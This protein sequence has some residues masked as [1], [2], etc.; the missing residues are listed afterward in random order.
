MPVTVDPN[1]TPEKYYEEVKEMWRKYPKD[2]NFHQQAEILAAT[3]TASGLV[4]DREKT[5]AA[6]MHTASIR[7]GVQL[8]HDMRMFNH[9][10]YEAVLHLVKVQ[11]IILIE[12]EY[13]QSLD[14][15]HD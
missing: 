5:I 7:A 11:D 12:I 3:S 9:A 6:L 13:Q 15:P 8:L 10:T 4:Y 14:K 2:A 1:Q